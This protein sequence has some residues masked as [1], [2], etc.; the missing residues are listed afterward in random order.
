[1]KKQLQGIAIILVSILTG[2]ILSLLDG[3]IGHKLCDGIRSVRS[4]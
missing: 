4:I 2:E 3:G 1:M